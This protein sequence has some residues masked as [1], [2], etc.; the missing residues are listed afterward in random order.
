[1]SCQVNNTSLVGTRWLLGA[2]YC[3][4]DAA[5]C[6]DPRGYKSAVSGL[7]GCKE[8][9]EKDLQDD[10]GYTH[11]EHKMGRKIFGAFSPAW[12]PVVPSHP[13]IGFLC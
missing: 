3:S 11:G 12:S 4:G 7:N 6:A 13:D 5:T 2:H 10:G 8:D 1:M 9:S